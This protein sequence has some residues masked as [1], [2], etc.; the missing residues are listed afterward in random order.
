MDEDSCSS[1]FHLNKDI[2]SLNKDLYIKQL[3]K[4]LFGLVGEDKKRNK[5]RYYKD[6][7]RSYRGITMPDSIFHSFDQLRIAFLEAFFIFIKIKVVS[8]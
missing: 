5:F 6:I 7:G 8:A 1:K 4:Y 3:L 2:H